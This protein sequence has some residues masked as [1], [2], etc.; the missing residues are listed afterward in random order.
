MLR[1]AF[2]GRSIPPQLSQPMQCQRW[3]DAPAGWRGLEGTPS[4]RSITCGWFVYQLE[5]AR[6]VSNSSCN[7][8][9]MQ[10]EVVQGSRR[11][12][13]L[14]APAWRFN[15]ILTLSVRTENCAIWHV[16]RAGKLGRSE[17]EDRI[18]RNERKL[19]AQAAPFDVRIPPEANWMA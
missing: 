6:S 12:R 8:I 9:I 19:S 13:K 11:D 2:W 10:A 3:G 1:A 16:P 7:L 15:V 14:S 18:S 5:S 17:W 4:G